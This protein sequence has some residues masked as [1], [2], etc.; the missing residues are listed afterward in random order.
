MA[1]LW[2]F[3]LRTDEQGCYNITQSVKDAIK[4]SGVE[5]GIAVV[6]C[7]HTTAGITITENHDPDVCEDVL[8][9]FDR[10]FPDM[11]DFKHMQGNSFAHLRSSA[12]GC[13]ITIIVDE[14]W[15]LLGVWQAVYFC[16]FDGPRT[17]EYYV[18]V[19]GDQMQVP[20]DDDDL[21]KED[22]NMGLDEEPLV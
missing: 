15:P 9:G 12:M 13:S 16:E 5:S 17:R 4:E 11:P 6:F 18:K 22:E 10:A 14:G 20:F 1:N 21:D 7:P 3:T 8:L 19:L 2:E